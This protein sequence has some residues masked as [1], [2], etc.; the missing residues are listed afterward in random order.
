ML[1]T[2]CP[3]GAAALPEDVPERPEVLREVSEV[4]EATIV[5]A[6][7]TAV[8]P[9]L[10]HRLRED[11]KEIV[12]AFLAEAEAEHREVRRTD[13][14]SVPP[15]FS[16]LVEHQPSL[17]SRDLV[18]LLISS[19]VFTGGAHADFRLEGIIYDL[20]RKVFVEP[21]DILAGGYGWP[22]NERLLKELVATKLRAQKRARLRDE[23]D[24][25]RDE[26]WLKGL[27]LPL[28][29]VTLVPSTEPG[30]IGGL[31]FHFAPYVA[32]PYA[33]GSYRVDVA[34]RE[35]AP[36]L[37]PAWRAA[38]AGE[39][40]SLVH[41][42]GSAI[43]EPAFVLIAEPQP[44]SVVGSSIRIAGEAPAYVLAGGSLKATISRSDGGLL[45][46]GKLAA[47]RKRRPSGTALGMVPFAGQ[48]EVTQG[49]GAALIRIGNYSGPTFSVTIHRK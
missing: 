20:R 24:A 35:L 32:G 39:P 11:A 12:K 43:G 21:E 7:E 31:A 30:R 29:A 27:T 38:F 5:L 18:S 49:E 47:D 19:E 34:A 17:V 23:Y 36:M 40:I 41:V 44:D 33:E 37:A 25:E 14:D 4:A 3:A 22:N 26:A 48:L 42:R 46:E 13:P 28:E 1:A 16:L 45:A 15:T 10:H 6:R 8:A 2:V 9:A